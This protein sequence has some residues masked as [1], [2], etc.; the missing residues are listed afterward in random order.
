MAWQDPLSTHA[1]ELM[2]THIAVQSGAEGVGQ[3]LPVAADVLF[4]V[5]VEASEAS[6]WPE[7][8]FS[9]ASLPPS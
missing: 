1:P 5:H 4:H 9:A 6:L 2:T 7:Q 3:R 8:L